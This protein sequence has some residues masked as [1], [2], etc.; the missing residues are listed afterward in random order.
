MATTA[1]ALFSDSREVKLAAINALGALGQ[2]NA[3]KPLQ[4]LIKNET[5][6]ELRKIAIEVYDTL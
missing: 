6:E 2:P 5:D 4:E 3:M 1:R